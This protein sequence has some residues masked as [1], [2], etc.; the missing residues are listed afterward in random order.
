M[1]SLFKD[2]AGELKNLRSLVI[3]AMLCAVNVVTSYFSISLSPTLKI[4][5][6]YLSMS[7]IGFLF[8]PVSGA[9]CGILLDT[10]KFIVNPSGPYN[11]LWALIEANSG[12]LF[13]LMLYK[14]EPTMI[15]CFVTKFIVSLIQNV[16]LTPLALTVTYRNSKG[17]IYYASARV[18]KNIILWPIESLLMFLVLLRIAIYIKKRRSY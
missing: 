8:G 1:L 4:A 15:R 14:K 7:M 13:G 10:V 16:I 12:I 9:F 3:M 2:S 18:V 6:S 17:F 5:F 11:P